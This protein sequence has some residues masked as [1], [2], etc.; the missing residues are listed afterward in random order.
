MGSQHGIC[1]DMIAAR[2]NQKGG[3]FI[4]VKVIFTQCLT[5]E[6]RYVR[7]RRGQMPFP[8]PA[9][10]AHTISVCCG[11]DAERSAICTADEETNRGGDRWLSTVQLRKLTPSVSVVAKTQHKDYC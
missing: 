11:Q 4:T 6:V 8:C 7:Q 2:G 3:H 9:Q 1:D 5:T 10:R